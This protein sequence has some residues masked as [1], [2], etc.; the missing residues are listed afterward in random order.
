M[1]SSLYCSVTKLF[2]GLCLG[3][4]FFGSGCNDH[5]EF[6]GSA[7]LAENTAD[8]EAETESETEDPDSAEASSDAPPASAKSQDAIEVENAKSEP[9]TAPLPNAGPASVQLEA[10]EAEIKRRSDGSVAE[11]HLRKTPATDAMA[12]EIGRFDKL[13]K[14]TINNSEMTGAGWAQLSNLGELQ[15]FD[16]RGCAVNNKQ[17]TAAIAGMP[18]LRALRLNGKSG[19]T[20]VD[21]LAMEALSKCTELKALA[22]DHL[23]VGVDGLKSLQA[24]TKL[25]ELYLAATLVDDEALEVIAGFPALKKLRIAQTS[26]SGE[27]MQHLT[28]LSLEDLD[29]S[30]CSVLNDD[31]LK[32]VGSFTTLKRLNLFKVPLSD[33]GVDNLAGLTAL[34]WMNLDQTGLTD[35]GMPALKGMTKMQFLHLGST[36][37]SDL[38]LE[39]LEAM[40]SLKNLIVTR[41]AVTETGVAEIKKSISGVEVQ[42]KYIEGE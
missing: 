17:L 18:R 38:G 4:L 39:H 8:A 41:T 22:L 29:A 34:T 40:Q 6:D 30:E 37:V 23:W 14:L 5:A 33:L 10:A 35:E 9:P 20:T 15:Q 26:V 11:V 42:L 7:Y 24:C 19:L 13:V 2:T 32:I 16:L 31:S 28:K 21:D 36:G 25:S 27:G 1:P 3:C 12:E